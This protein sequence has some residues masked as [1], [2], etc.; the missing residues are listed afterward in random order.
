MNVEEQAKH[1]GHHDGGLSKNL[2][3]KVSLLELVRVC[4]NS[5]GYGK[6]N[7]VGLIRFSQPRADSLIFEAFND[8]FFLR[9]GQEKQAL[10]N[11]STNHYHS[12]SER[13]LAGNP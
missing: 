2:F 7:K 3:L 9:A 6:L 12:G 1:V 10:C 4:S 5:N 11:L 13:Y 8:I